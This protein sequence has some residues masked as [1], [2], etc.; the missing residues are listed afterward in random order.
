DIVTTNSLHVVYSVRGTASNGVDYVLLPG[1]VDIPAGAETAN[2][3]VQPI[4]DEVMEGV[5]TVTI[6]LSGFAIVF[7][8][9]FPQVVPYQVGVPG[10]AGV[11]IFDNDRPFGSPVTLVA[12]GSVW[13]YLTGVPAP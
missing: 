8:F 13:K 4:D 10:T 2:I 12:T 7:G 1:Y 5:E 9:G 3:V 6:E 11:N